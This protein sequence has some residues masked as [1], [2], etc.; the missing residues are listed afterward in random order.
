METV[1]FDDFFDTFPE[2]LKRDIHH[3]VDIVS[4]AGGVCRIVGGAVRDR[5]LGRDISD[6]DLECYGLDVGLFETLTE[7][8]GADG[9]GRAFFVGDFVDVDFP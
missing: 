6:V 8:I 5:V 9:V 1:V 2:E 3:I 4:R 7:S